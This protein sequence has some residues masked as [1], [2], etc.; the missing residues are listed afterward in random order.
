[1]HFS[2]TIEPMYDEA[3]AL[4]ENAHTFTIIQ[5]ENP[6]G[7]SLASALALEEILGDMQKETFLYCPVE[8]PKYLRYIKGWDRVETDFS[9]HADAAIIVDTS[10]DVLISKVLETPG[11]RH[12]LE[13]HPVLVIDHHTTASTLS[14]DHTPLNDTA[15]STSEVIYKLAKQAKWPIN[16]PAAEH[17]LEA[18]LAD[19]LGL[20]IQTVSPESYRIAA[21]LTEL[22]AHVAEIEERRR[23]FMKK[24]PEI[25]AYKGELLQRIEY[26]LE[27]KLAL[28]HIPF[29]EIEQYSDKY[30]P[31]VLV[32]DEMR[33]VDDVEVAIAIK[34]YP[35]GKLTGKL[36]SNLP[37]SETIAGYFGGGGHP[38]AAGFRVYES[39][40]KIVEELLNATEKALAS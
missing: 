21:D 39:Y 18:Q 22:G 15:I 2:A 40:D 37:V 10:A 36:R 27:G 34:T 24:A 19:S 30:N 13:S 5:A 3:K 20:S 25:L 12:F 29:E 32:L 6:D 7:D 33:L 14:F 31:S 17:L 35:D 8:I 1:M 9:P 11:V 16:A 4:I 23:E 28:I 38:Y 26:Y